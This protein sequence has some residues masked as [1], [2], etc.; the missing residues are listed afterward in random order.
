[1]AIKDFDITKIYW[2]ISE[3]AEK[4]SV[5]QSLIRFWEKEFDELK[6]KKNQSG[7]RMFT[8]KDLDTFENIFHL[9][10]TEGMTLEGAKK[11]LKE[12]RKKD[13][14]PKQ[15]I[16]LSAEQRLLQVKEKLLDLKKILDL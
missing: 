1:M 13:F 10:K 8:K 6:P 14:G 2:S 11:K 15:P 16:D 9:V 3:V 7:N 4:F 12:M 5:S